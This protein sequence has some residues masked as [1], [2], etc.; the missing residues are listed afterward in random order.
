MCDDLVHGFYLCGIKKKLPLEKLIITIF[1]ARKQRISSGRI[2]V[3]RDVRNYAELV[4]YLKQVTSKFGS[5][6]AFGASQC[7]K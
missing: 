6:L 2:T 3:L 1:G 7:S 5:S 4:E